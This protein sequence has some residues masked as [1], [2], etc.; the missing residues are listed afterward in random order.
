MREEIKA[1]LQNPSAWKRLLYMIL[2]AV[3]YNVAEMVLV[4]VVILQ[5]LINLFTGNSNKYL[6][7]F[8]KQLSLYIYGVMKFLTY[9]TERLHFPFSE[10]PTALSEQEQT[11]K[12]SRPSKL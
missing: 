9:N 2:F 7:T 3:L 6:L 1:H 4:V 10:W 11:E 5:F 12:E 8:G